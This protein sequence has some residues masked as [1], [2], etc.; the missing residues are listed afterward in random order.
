M[1]SLSSPAH[2]PETKASLSSARDLSSPNPLGLWLFVGSAIVYLATRLISLESFP[3]YFF[4][5]EAIHSVA[6]RELVS[7]GFYSVEEPNEFLPAFFRNGRMLNLSLSVYVQGIASYLG[8]QSV[9]TVRATSALASLTGAVAL[10]LLLRRIFRVREW[11]SVVAFLTVMPGLFLHA[12]TGFECVLMFAGY[13]WFLYFY[14]LYREVSPRYILG[15]VFFGA[16]TFYSYSPGQGLMLATVALIAV[17]DFRYHYANRAWALAGLAFA[18]LL[19][20]P[21]VRFRLLHPEMVADHLREV[22]SYWV[23]PLPLSAKLLAFGQAYLGGFDPRY[24]FGVESPEKV[25]RHVVPFNGYVPWP[26]APLALAGLAIC[27]RG[28]RDARCRMILFATLASAFSGALA[29]PGITRNLVFLAV[30][31]VFATLGFDWVLQFVR[32]VRANQFL[33][34]TSFGLLSC[35]GLVLL[36]DAFTFGPTRFRN[37]GLGG[38]QWGSQAVFRDLIPRYLPSYPTANIFVS[39]TWANS[40]EVFPKFFGWYDQHRVNYLSLDQVISGAILPRDRDLVVLTSREYDRFAQQSAVGTFEVLERVPWPDGRIGFYLGH[41]H[42]RPEFVQEARSRA[43][44]IKRP[45]YIR[46]RVAGMPSSVFIPKLLSEN[47]DELFLSTPH[48]PL[49][50]APGKE[51]NV[52]VYFDAPVALTQ[53]QIF[54]ADNSPH[55]HLVWSTLGAKVVVEERNFV[56]STDSEIV[57]PMKGAAVSGLFFELRGSPENSLRI[58]EI[59]VVPVS[60]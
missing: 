25:A 55:Q 45:E 35:A 2:S 19:F 13:C 5:D 17:G 14:L 42:L 15:A 41:L 11:W 49:V 16:V 43:D 12:R 7:N 52:A 53:V 34:V 27:L 36:H 22:R 60:P 30:V 10:A 56:P 33:R 28:W 47:D 32:S 29:A 18:L 26:L 48:P 59:R 20:A 38:L 46:L 3:I 50:I 40:P 39:H 58:Q 6:F 21:Y 1:N 44:F 54:F 8:G 51:M 23:K 57:I 31:A 24:W 4:C 9:F 37:Y